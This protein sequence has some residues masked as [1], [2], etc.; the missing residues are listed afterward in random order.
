[1][2]IEERLLETE[3]R[4]LETGEAILCVAGRDDRETGTR[5]VRWEV[6]QATGELSFWVL[7]EDRK[8]GVMERQNDEPITA[9]KDP[10][11]EVSYSWVDET[12]GRRG[13]HRYYIESLQAPFYLAQCSM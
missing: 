13:R 8:R 11:G 12:P 5:T 9:I 4:L 7:R 1:L 10:D 3:L 6:L 2:K